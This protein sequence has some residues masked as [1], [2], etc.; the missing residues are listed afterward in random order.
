MQF[1]DIDTIVL[2]FHLL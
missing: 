2:Y 1:R